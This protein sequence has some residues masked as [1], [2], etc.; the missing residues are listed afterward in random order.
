M[1]MATRPRTGR[2][3]RSGQG[4]GGQRWRG[5]QQGLEMRLTRMMGGRV[6]KNRENYGVLADLMRGWWTF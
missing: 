6:E 1:T 2:N 3:R 5:R 4:G